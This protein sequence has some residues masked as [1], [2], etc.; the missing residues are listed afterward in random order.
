MKLKSLSQK[1][2]ISYV[3]WVGW[4]MK[5][6]EKRWHRRR[7]GEAEGRLGFF[8]YI[9][10]PHYGIKEHNFHPNICIYLMP[11]GKAFSITKIWKKP[12]EKFG[13]LLLNKMVIIQKSIEWKPKI[14][15]FPTHSMEISTKCPE[16]KPQKTYTALIRKS[17]ILCRKILFSEF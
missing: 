5:I 7:A 10:T 9:F 8:I 13:G 1:I 2:A 11:C 12:P 14:W 3:K 16:I 6:H 15:K 4:R 17:H